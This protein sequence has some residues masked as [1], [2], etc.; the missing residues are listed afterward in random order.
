MNI[1]EDL[2][3]TT[4]SNI[5]EDELKFAINISLFRTFF[6]LA[7]MANSLVLIGIGLNKGMQTSTDLL[8]FYLIMLMG[9]L[10][11]LPSCSFEKIRFFFKHQVSSIYYW[12]KYMKHLTLIKKSSLINNRS[13]FMKID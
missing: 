7:L 2:D 12:I 10:L 3:S 5:F 4:N 13:N 6:V 9:D 11:M 8:L 1:N